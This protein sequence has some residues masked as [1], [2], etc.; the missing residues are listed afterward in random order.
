MC[1]LPN[2]QH[3][4]RLWNADIIAKETRKQKF[5]H[6]L[7]IVNVICVWCR[8][9]TV[10]GFDFFQSPRSI[11]VMGALIWPGWS[12]DSVGVHVTQVKLGVQF[13]DKIVQVSF[14]FI[15]SFKILATMQSL[16]LSTSISGDNP[17]AWAWH[18]SCLACFIP[19][20]IVIEVVAHWLG[21]DQTRGNMLL[22]QLCTR[23]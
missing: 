8:L 14:E 20:H 18:P 1:P 7:L 2:G 12:L 4:V 10:N 11:I 17:I 3:M 23:V 13:I 19:H 5:Q 9:W 21:T 16:R 15:S 6:R 22:K